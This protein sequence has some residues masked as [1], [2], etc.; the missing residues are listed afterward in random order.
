MTAARSAMIAST[1]TISIRTTP[2]SPAR[3]SALPALDVRGRSAPALLSIRTI[4]DDVIGAVLAGRAINVSMSPRIVGNEAAAQIRPVPG[5]GAPRPLGE[6]RK[7]LAGR[8]I[9]A[10]VEVEQVERARERL[11]LDARGLDL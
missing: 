3:P 9:T 6:C 11:D 1:A 8:R 7:A 10:V 5:L 2:R 4:P